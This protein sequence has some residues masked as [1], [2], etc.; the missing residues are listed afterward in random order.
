MGNN[1]RGRF[2]LETEAAPLR[3]TP[4]HHMIVSLHVPYAAR[5]RAPDGFD[6]ARPPFSSHGGPDL[7]E[8]NPSARSRQPLA[9]ADETIFRNRRNLPE[10]DGRV[11]SWQ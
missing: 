6:P 7:G 10:T 3:T 4:F 8:T 1:G 5:C 2:E 9:R 11:S